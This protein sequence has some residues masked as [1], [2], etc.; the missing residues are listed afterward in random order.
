MLKI[1]RK[2]PIKLNDLGKSE[3]IQSLNINLKYIKT[4]LDFD[5][6]MTKFVMNL[7]NGY[8]RPLIKIIE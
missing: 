6:S 3:Q 5:G 1:L 7:S 8:N 2:F 4:V